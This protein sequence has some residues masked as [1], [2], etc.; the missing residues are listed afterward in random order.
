MRF[1]YHKLTSKYWWRRQIYQLQ[2]LSYIWFIIA[3][4][5][6]FCLITI[7]PNLFTNEYS[8]ILIDQDVSWNNV[9]ELL[10]IKDQVNYQEKKTFFHFFLIL[11]FFFRFFSMIHYQ[12]GLKLFNMEIINNNLHLLFLLYFIQQYFAKKNFVHIQLNV[13]LVNLVHQKIVVNGHVIIQNIV[14]L[15]H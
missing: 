15:M 8:R 13:F 12:I 7:E 14:K 3:F 9:D 11:F 10:K 4:I 1:L 2:H 6:I 5:C